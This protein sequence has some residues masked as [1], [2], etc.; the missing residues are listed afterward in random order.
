MTLI[1]EPD[2]GAPAARSETR[3]TLTIGGKSVTVPEGASIMRA[4]MG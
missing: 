3:V 1:E 4:A 2:F